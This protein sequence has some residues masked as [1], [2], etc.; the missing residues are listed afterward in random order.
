MTKRKLSDCN[1]IAITHSSLVSEW[2]PTKNDGLTPYDVISGSHKNVWWLCPVGEDHEWRSS[3]K[4]RALNGQGCGVCAG[5]VIV[6]SNSLGGQRPDVACLWHPVKNG[7]L[8]PFEVSSRSGKI[9]WWQ[10]LRDSSHEYLD[11]PQKR[12]ISYKEGGVNCPICYGRRV[13]SSTS[14]AENSPLI[15]L[16]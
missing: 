9:V 5:K 15:S 13:I 12:V 3:I 14:L 4:N 8:T 6:I 7:S 1:S 2:H 11:S 10:C 16:E